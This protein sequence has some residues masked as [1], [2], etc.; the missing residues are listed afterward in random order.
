VVSTCESSPFSFRFRVV[1]RD[2]KRFYLA[3]SSFLR[4]T[5]NGG[6]FGAVFPTGTVYGSV[7]IGALPESRVDLLIL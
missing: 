2:L 3:G 1:L 6:L 5:M 7:T 4:L